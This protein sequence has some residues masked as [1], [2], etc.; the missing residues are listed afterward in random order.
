MHVSLLWE[1][2]VAIL[3]S[4]SQSK[5]KRGKILSKNVAINLL[6]QHMLTIEPTMVNL[7]IVSLMAR[8]VWY[9]ISSLL[10]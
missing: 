2:F 10:N 1:K 9:E 7:Q 6:G 3:C 4:V 8:E 5:K